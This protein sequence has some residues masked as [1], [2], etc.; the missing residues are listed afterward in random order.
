MELHVVGDRIVFCK[1]RI[2]CE[3]PDPAASEDL[4]G[5]TPW[6][7]FEKRLGG[8]RIEAYG[9][10]SDTD[11]ELEKIEAGLTGLS[12]SYTVEDISPTAEQMARADEMQG[13]VGSRTQAL[14]YILNNVAPERI[15][16][17]KEIEELKARV[18]SLIK[19]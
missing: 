9:L 19:R 8:Y 6:E 11:E 12:I 18:E 2:N 16:R 14:H 1:W 13:K 15:A 10:L 5:E 7:R 4:D 17:D 3:V